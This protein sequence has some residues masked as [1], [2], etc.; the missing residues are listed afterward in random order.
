MPA[1]GATRA[2]LQQ[3]IVA[4]CCTATESNKHNKYDFSS[5]RKISKHIGATMFA[6]SATCGIFVA[7]VTFAT[8]N[9]AEIFHFRRGKTSQS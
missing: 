1:A 2:Q 3:T 9:H 6:T 5:E 4:Y 8:K 7:I